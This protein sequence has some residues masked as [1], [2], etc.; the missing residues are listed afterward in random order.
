MCGCAREGEVH[1]DFGHLPLLLSILFYERLFQWPWSS[2]VQE[3]ELP[4]QLH[5]PCCPYS[6]KDERHTDKFLIAC[7]GFELR[8][9][10]LC[11]KHFIDWAICSALHN[12][13]FNSSLYLFGS[14]VYTTVFGFCST[15]SL[16]DLS[17][18]ESA[19]A[20]NLHVYVLGFK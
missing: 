20:E 5:F 12:L 9:S 11:C 19:H 16:G 14:F 8:S 3:D 18:I 17:K 2:S 7:W 1:T 10:F 13:S 15:I 4:S 6:P